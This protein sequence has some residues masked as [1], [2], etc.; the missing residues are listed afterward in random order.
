MLLNTITAAATGA[1]NM[2]SSYQMKLNYYLLI[3]LE[4]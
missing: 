1:K 3:S 4:N 2:I